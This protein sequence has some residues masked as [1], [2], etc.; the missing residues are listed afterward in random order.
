M[1][2]INYISW[3][4]DTRHNKSRVGYRVVYL[5]PDQVPDTY[6]YKKINGPRPKTQELKPY[7]P[8]PT[9]QVHRL[10]ISKT[11]PNYPNPS[12]SH[13]SLNSEV[14]SDTKKN[15]IPN[16]RI[17]N[18]TTGPDSRP[19]LKLLL[20][21]CTSPMDSGAGESSAADDYE[22][23]MSTTD[24]ELLKRAWRN[25]K[26]APEILKFEADLV[27]RSRQQIQL[28]VR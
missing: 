13:S 24:E 4:P 27:H 20:H 18:P 3:V 25:E 2:K 16:S 21:F 19:Y 5:L 22:S 6:V 26:A 11:R 12:N 1:K 7:G 14:N 8:N 23:L 15:S 9:S 10:P 17:P 28:M